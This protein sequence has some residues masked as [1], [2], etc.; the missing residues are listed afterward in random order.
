MQS[1]LKAASP[2]C[3]EPEA[4]VGQLEGEV[5]EGSRPWMGVRANRHPKDGIEPT[6]RMPWTSLCSNL[7]CC[8]KRAEKSS[9]HLHPLK[10]TGA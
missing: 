1:P 9:W 8:S 3:A 10:A 6:H 7:S 2:P 5:R 4:A